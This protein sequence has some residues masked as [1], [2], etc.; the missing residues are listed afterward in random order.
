MC[1]S[2]RAPEASRGEP[3]RGWQ[4]AP[5]ARRG[6]VAA[7]PPPLT[8]SLSLSSR[9]E[10]RATSC[11]SS[12]SLPLSCPLPLSREQKK[13]NELLQH[14]AQLLE[15]YLARVNPAAA[16]TSADGEGDDAAKGG[17]KPKAKR[18]EVD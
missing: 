14:E 18:R 13:S 9:A 7:G 3:G 6:R 1:S 17:R 10:E 2:S 8:L 12:R 15:A 4:S 11:C 16:S 5:P